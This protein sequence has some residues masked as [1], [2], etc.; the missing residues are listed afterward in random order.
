MKKLAFDG[1]WSML[2]LGAYRCEAMM[3]LMSGNHCTT[4]F[5]GYYPY[6]CHDSQDT[7]LTLQQQ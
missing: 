4:Y 3:I 6:T 1:M 7:P 2:A 5:H